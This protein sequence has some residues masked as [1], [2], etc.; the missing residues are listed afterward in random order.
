MG[1][2]TGE[3]VRLDALVSRLHSEGVNKGKAEAEKILDDARQEAEQ[4][5]QAAQTEA[6][7][8][9]RSAEAEAAKLEQSA[10]ASVQQ[11]A[12]DTMLALTQNVRGLFMKAF[13]EQT[14]DVL[15]DVEFLRELIMQLVQVWAGGE[16][17]TVAV[18]PEMGQ[19]LLALADTGVQNLLAE[20]VEIRLNRSITNGFRIRKDG[21]AVAYD[22]SDA[23]VTESFSAYLNPQLTKLLQL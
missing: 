1:E 4:I 2:N 3:E 20:G 22:V 15:N 18:S 13:R 23:T 17:V 7:A 14:G 19:K 11:A 9:I 10:T 16:A 5:L 6:D 21:D 8:R 12:R